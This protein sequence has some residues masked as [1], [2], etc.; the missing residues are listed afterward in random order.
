MMQLVGEGPDLAF[1]EQTFTSGN[2]KVSKEGET[3]VILSER[4]E[5][6]TDPHAVKDVAVRLAAI[7]DGVCRLALNGSEP[8]EIGNGM[9]RDDSTGKL[10]YYLMP[11]TGHYRL[12]GIPAGLSALAEDANT[13]SHDILR[14]WTA[15]ALTDRAV[16][17]VL[18]INALAPLDWVSLYRVAEIIWNDVGGQKVIGERDWMSDADLSLFTWTANSADALGLEARHGVQKGKAPANPM[19][20]IDARQLVRVLTWKWLQSKA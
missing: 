15:L 18:R 4:F 14:A 17:N 1:L 9:Y 10:H 6:L 12:R 8:L 5:G 11:E 3:Y 2:I 16:A 19:E 7:L 13:S 20:L